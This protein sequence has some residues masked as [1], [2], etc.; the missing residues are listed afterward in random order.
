MLSIPAPEWI[1]FSEEGGATY[2]VTLPV[3]PN[4]KLGTYTEYPFSISIDEINDESV[5]KVIEQ[6]RDQ[7]ASLVPVED[8]GAATDDYAVIKFIGRRDGEPVDGAQSDRTP[9]DH[10][11]RAVHSR[12]R[13]PLIGQR[14]DDKKTFSVTFPDDYRKPSWPARTSSSRWP[15]GAARKATARGGR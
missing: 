4:V 1:S 3:R 13:R 7:Q 6:L 14:E 8:R 2:Q 5:D 15:A 10:R 12:F 11:P 9:V